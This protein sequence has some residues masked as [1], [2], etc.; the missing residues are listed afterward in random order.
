M[1]VA[2]R[3]IFDG[4]KRK[5]LHL[6]NDAGDIET[7][8]VKIDVSA[9]T[10]NDGQVPSYVTLDMIDYHTDG[11]VTLAFDATAGDIIAVLPAGQGTLDFAAYG[12]F[13]DPRSAGSTGDVVLTA[14]GVNYTI[15]I[16]FRPKS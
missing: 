16:H 5:L 1:A 7:A 10:F 2:S 11:E 13:T 12:G 14:T 8:A 9:I 15:D 3:Y 4:R 6:T